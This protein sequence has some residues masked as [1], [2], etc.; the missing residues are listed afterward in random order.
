MRTIVES[1]DRNAFFFAVRASEVQG[2]GLPMSDGIKILKIA[3]QG[4]KYRVETSE[5][6]T[7]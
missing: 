6:S 5:G 7:F 4:K 1:I 3:K 2:E